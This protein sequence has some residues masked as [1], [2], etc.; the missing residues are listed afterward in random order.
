MLYCAYKSFY[1]WRGPIL[2]NREYG[3]PIG[4]TEIYAAYVSII[5]SSESNITLG[6][7]ITLITDTKQ[8]TTFTIHDGHITN[9]S[10][11]ALFITKK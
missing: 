11:N 7:Y 10:C 3:L 2:S 5:N 1:Q 6:I 4:Y 8:F 9:R